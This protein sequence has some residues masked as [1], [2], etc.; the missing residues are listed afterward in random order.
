MVC[1]AELASLKDTF[2]LDAWA[3]NLFGLTIVLV[4]LCGVL[5]LTG[6]S[7]RCFMNES[8]RRVRMVLQHDVVMK[9]YA[10]RMMR[11]RAEDLY[12]ASD[13]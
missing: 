9:E 5:S 2:D 8:K 6:V 12:K 10:K 7:L 1:Q 3:R 11:K 4:L 13:W